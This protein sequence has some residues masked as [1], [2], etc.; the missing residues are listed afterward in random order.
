[1]I[2]WGFGSLWGGGGGGEISHLALLVNLSYRLLW[3]RTL[4]TSFVDLRVVG[5]Q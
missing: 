1:M 2:C 5:M 3:S 4:S